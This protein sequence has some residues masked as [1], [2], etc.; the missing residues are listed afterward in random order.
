M[1]IRELEN[2][3]NEWLVVELKQCRSILGIKQSD[4]A[5]L[6]GMAIPSIKRL[7]KKGSQPRYTSINKIRKTFRDLGLICLFSDE[8]EIRT[9]LSPKLVEA[10]NE[11]QLKTYIKAYIDKNIAEDK[12]KS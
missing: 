2:E 3:Q 12:K 4:L 1:I 9:Q 6:T 5:Q 11:G 8:G 10:I 7:E